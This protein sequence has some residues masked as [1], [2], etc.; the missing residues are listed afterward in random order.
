MPTTKSA[1]KRLRSGA[2]RHLR[3]KM[4]KS[5]CRTMEKTFL[6]KVAQNDAEGAKAALNA[7]LS[8]FD[9]AAKTGTIH[10]NKADRKK[11]RL[12]AKLRAIPAKS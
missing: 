1:A 9:K 2:K 10:P 4:R 3:N 8:V 11:Q 6:A 12:T 5:L 7:C